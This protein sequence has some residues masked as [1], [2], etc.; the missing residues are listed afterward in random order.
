MALVRREHFHSFF[1][2]ET[3]EENPLPTHLDIKPDLL[4]LLGVWE[5][6]S[7]LQVQGEMAFPSWNRGRAGREFLSPAADPVGRQHSE[8]LALILV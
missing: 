1:V 3:G 2:A 5:G 7:Q 8:I 4:P 6:Q